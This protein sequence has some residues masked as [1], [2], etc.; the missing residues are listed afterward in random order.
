MQERDPCAHQS[1]PCSC[2]T[3]ACRRRGPGSKDCALCLSKRRATVVLNCGGSLGECVRSG[4]RQQVESQKGILVWTRR[5]YV[6]V[7]AAKLRG[8]CQEL[9]QN[10]SWLYALSPAPKN[11]KK[12]KGVETVHELRSVGQGL[13]R[14]LPWPCKRLKSVVLK[15][16]KPYPRGGLCVVWEIMLY[17]IQ[18]W[19]HRS[20]RR[21]TFS[22]C[23][24]T[25]V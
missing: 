20:A 11:A 22:Q 18:R 15:Y 25:V 4:G 14:G 24:H 13:S 5:I 1:P 17:G 16:S 7:R 6:R 19:G 23:F 3:T 21:Q 2:I 8:L 12:L 10:S 9:G